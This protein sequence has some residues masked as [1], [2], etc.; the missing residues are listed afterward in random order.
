MTY[1][2]KLTNH[3]SVGPW[4]DVGEF[5]FSRAI[6][7]HINHSRQQVPTSIR[8]PLQDWDDLKKGI[9]TCSYMPEK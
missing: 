7:S 8:Q 5:H 4:S 6:I 1:W 3:D 9:G 2:I